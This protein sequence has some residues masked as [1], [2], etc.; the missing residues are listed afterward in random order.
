MQ[1]VN[2]PSTAG[3]VSH[4]SEK[5]TRTLPH[6]LEFCW[7]LYMLLAEGK[8]QGPEGLL[9]GCYIHSYCPVLTL[10]TTTVAALPD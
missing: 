3:V 5:P 9:D 1:G 6:R 4:R 7:A 2:D 10:E 8:Y